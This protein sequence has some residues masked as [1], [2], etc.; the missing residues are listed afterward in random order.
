MWNF[1]LVFF[2]FLNQRVSLSIFL[3]E[4][5]AVWKVNDLLEKFGES[6]HLQ[7]YE[8]F[9]EWKPSLPKK[10]QWKSLQGFN[11]PTHALKSQLLHWWISLNTLV[12][13]WFNTIRH[14]TH[15]QNWRRVNYMNPI[16]QL[17][18]HR[19]FYSSISY[20]NLPEIAYHAVTI[21]LKSPILD[22]K[23]QI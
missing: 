13:N 20:S 21:P 15:P 14:L 10:F 22:P 11:T 1:K 19:Y 23:K 16:V 17:A 3:K 6:R 8:P 4:I 2:F 5:I 9:K 7:C 18:I 12:T